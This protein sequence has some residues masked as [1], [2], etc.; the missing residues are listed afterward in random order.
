MTHDGQN[1]NRF[2][3]KAAM[4]RLQGPNHFLRHFFVRPPATLPPWVERLGVFTDT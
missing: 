2:C 1:S 4:R 3:S